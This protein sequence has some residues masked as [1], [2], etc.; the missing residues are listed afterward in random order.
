MVKAKPVLFVFVLSFLFSNAQSL[1]ITTPNGGE[2]WIVGN[3]YPIHWDWTGNIS[4]VRLDYSTDGG[5]N[6]TLIASSTTNDGDYLWT[7]NNTISQNCFVKISSTAN[8]AIYDLSDGSFSIVR[9]TID[10]KKPDGGEILRIGEYF[11]IHWNWTGQFSNVKIEYSTDGGSSWNNIITSTQ[12]DGEYYWQIPNAPSSNCRIK[13]TNTIDP[14][15][16][17]ISDYDFTIAVNTI[18]VLQPNGGESYTTG[19]IYPIYWD[20]TGSFSN[21][22]IEYST[23]GGN[24]W[25]QIIASTPNDGS[26]NWTIPNNPATNCRIRI[27]NTQDA[28]CYDISDADFTILSTGVEV[29]CPNGGENYIVGDA[30]AIHWNWLGVISNVK[31]EYSSDGGVTWNQITSSTSNDGDYIWT[32]PNIPTTQCRIKITNLADP[33]CYDMSNANF[34]VQAPSFTILDPDSGKEL[35]AGETYPVHWNWRGAVSS[36]KLEL[37]YKTQTGVQW[38]TITNSTPNDGSYYFTVPYYISDSCGIKLTSNDDANC[39]ALSEVFEIVRPT[40][41]IVYPNG[42][43]YIYE[44]DFIEVIWNS[45][46]NFS[47]VMLQYS[48][49]GGQDWQTIT[50]STPNDG[51]FR[52]RFCGTTAPFLSDSI[53]IKI[54]NTSDLNCFD[55]TDSVVH[56]MTY[57]LNIARP[58]FGDKYYINHRH[59]IYWR[60]PWYS[61]AYSIQY[62][63]NGGISWS[64]IANS[65]PPTGAYSWKVDTFPSS[66]AYVK[67]FG[68]DSG[69]SAQF[70]IE[71]TTS[72]IQNLKILAP[73]GRDTFGMGGDTFAI[74]GKCYITWHS[75]NFQPPNQVAIYYSIDGS[76]WVLI[77][78]TSNTS[79][80]Y[81]WTIPNYVTDSCRILI[82]DVNGTASDTSG[83]FTIV[84]QEIVITSPSAIKEWIVGRKYYI[85][86]HWTGGFANVDLYYSYDG[87]ATWVSIASPTP[88]DGEYEWTIPNAPSTQCLIR[89]RNFENSNVVAISD[90]FTIK[91]QEIFVTYPIQSDSF[92][93]GRKYFVTWDYTGAFSNVN[94]EYSING[95]L[96]WTPVASNVTNNQYYE[97]TIPNT[98]TNLAMV[99]V[100]NASNL[101][102]YGL[103][104]TFKILPQTIEVTS[105]VLNSQWI[106]GRNYYITWRYTG[107]FNNVKIEYSYDGGNLWN[108]IVESATNSNNYEWT[109]P[110][111]PSDNCFVKVS[112]YNNLNVYDISEWFR[113]PLQIINITSPKTGDELI[114]GRKYYITWQ[115]LGSFSS[116]DIQY[117]LDSGSTWTYVATN[118]PNNGSY[119]W[120]VPTANSTTS[121]VKLSNPQNPNVYDIS[122]VFSILPQEITI[123]SPIY[124]DTLLSGRKYYLTWRTYGAFSNA[125]LWYSLDGGQNWTPIATNVQNNGYYE[126]SIPEVISNIARIK[127]ANNSQNSIYAL[128][129]TFIIGPPI[130]EIASPALG[131][132]WYQNRKYYI[133]WN[134]LGVI[135]QVNLFYS[136]DGGGSWSQIVANQTNQGNYEWTIPQGIS[137]ENSRIRLVSSA[138]SSIF[139]TSDSF[140]IRLTG[141]EEVGQK[142]IPTE[143]S[144]QGILPNPFSQNCKVMLALPVDAK[145]KLK[146]YDITGRIVDIIYDGFVTAGYHSITYNKKLPNGVYFLRFEAER[147]KK[148]Y[149][150]VVKVLKI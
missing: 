90:T 122:D 38:W 64:T 144:L 36:V 79:R 2:S 130:L 77:T 45:N 97:W 6:W 141:I 140:V 26:Y 24:T 25:T 137:S 41:R 73:I 28:N 117:S 10:I 91:P 3:K 47:D 114:S 74:G 65:V 75:T 48:D 109:I 54:I 50:T 35:V 121:L 88:N 63:T 59:P 123:T 49:N 12:N 51:S 102:A 99:K 57:I 44:G 69:L 128:S 96:N 11:P 83:P 78:T 5:N 19:Q 42:G 40:I 125:D 85:L 66:D 138:N 46:G 110:N 100:I 112:N 118:V 56:V 34:T 115:W 108:T 8:P 68:N 39:F 136:T 13:I 143:F 1:I 76:P 52:W 4:S 70:T 20:W 147:G 134:Q 149:D 29:I 94:I 150:C 72:L 139:Y 129:D 103:S 14:E 33:N 133:T 89:I 31:I 119:E 113:I 58:K 18:T 84:P 16:F 101:E 60:N 124:G 30:C 146:L 127:I 71:D 55:I 135:T 132:I 95:G 104:D 15:C 80:S 9:P 7:I 148:I 116:V 120:T 111:T 126:W 106:I 17:N 82:S 21:V 67:V 93:V 92:I 105:P 32:I 142:I 37:W 98:P 145:I 27:T 86:W 131:N 22:K 107:A 81:E 87:G 53:L 62:S 23:D 61:S 43:E